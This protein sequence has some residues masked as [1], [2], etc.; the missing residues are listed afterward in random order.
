M[1]VNLT[2]KFHNHNPRGTAMK[3]CPVNVLISSVI[4]FV[5][6]K[7]LILVRLC[8]V[9]LAIEAYGSRIK[10]HFLHLKLAVSNW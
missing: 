1:Q 4:R 5:Q 7:Q 9:L 3:S 10:I 6:K 2:R 8:F